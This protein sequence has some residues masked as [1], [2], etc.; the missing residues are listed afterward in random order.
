MTAKYGETVFGHAGVLGTV[1]GT[2]V[3]I[4]RLEECECYWLHAPVPDPASGEAVVA[5]RYIAGLQV[6]FRASAR[7]SGSYLRVAIHETGCWSSAPAP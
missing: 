1:L 2:E 3:S 6:P 5:G 7:T 4:R